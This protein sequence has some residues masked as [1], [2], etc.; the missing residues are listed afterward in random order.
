MERYTYHENGK[1]RM[2]IGDTE[3]SGRAADRLAAYE[4]TGMEPEEIQERID[5]EMGCL[6]CFPNRLCGTCKKMLD[7]YDDGGSDK[8]SAEMMG[9]ACADYTPMAA[10]PMCGRKLKTAMPGEEV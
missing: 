6:L 10:C 5:R 9:K 2:R 3:Y 1:W 4:D 8:C 7:Y